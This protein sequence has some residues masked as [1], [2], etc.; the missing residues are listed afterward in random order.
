MVDCMAKQATT[1]SPPQIAAEYPPTELKK[2]ISPEKH[3]ECAAQYAYIPGNRYT[4]LF[5]FLKR[6]PWFYRVRDAKPKSFYR[7][8]TRLRTRHGRTNSRIHL[9]DPLTLPDCPRCPEDAET[10]AHIISECSQY[11]ADRNDLLSSIP[12]DVTSPFNLDT[13]I[14]EEKLEVYECIDDFLD[15]IERSL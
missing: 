9:F 13:L 8:I 2:K 6:N 10:M 3:L 15:K 11:E 1:R 7:N 14:A 5:P 4:N 12:R